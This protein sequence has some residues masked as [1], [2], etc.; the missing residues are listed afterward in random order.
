MSDNRSKILVVDDDEDYQAAVRKILE[1]AGYEV[2]SAFNKQEGLESL[3]TD[4]PDLLIL[5]IMMDKSTDGFFFLYEMGE[6]EGMERPPVLSV[7]VIEEETGMDFSPTSDED[8]FPA[9]DFL[10]KPV[11]PEEL[12]SRVEKLL[13]R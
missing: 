1:D 11:D 10:S 3:H 12:I 5:D 7:S 4:D 6:E 2:V 13:S 8:Y 9:D